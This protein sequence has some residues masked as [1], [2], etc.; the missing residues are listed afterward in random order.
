MTVLLVRSK[1]VLN[2]KTGEVGVGET[3]D[4][5]RVDSAETGHTPWPGKLK[6]STNSPSGN[7]DFGVLMWISTCELLM[8]FTSSQRSVSLGLKEDSDW[9]RISPILKLP[10]KAKVKALQT[11]CLLFSSQFD[12][13]ISC[14]SNFKVCKF[15]TFLDG[16]PSNE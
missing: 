11:V 12:I 16:L 7:L 2:W 5:F 9:D 1:P 6:M 10:K 14:P 4:S 15:I 3:R 8:N 13:A